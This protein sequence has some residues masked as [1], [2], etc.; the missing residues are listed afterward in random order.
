[1]RLHEFPD[2]FKELITIVAKSKSLP[3]SA[4]ERDYYIVRLLHNLATSEYADKCVFKGGTSLSKCYPGSIERFSEDIDLTYLGGPGM[5]DK[6]YSKNIKRI[7]AVMTVG[8]DTEKID[9]ERNDRN[10]SMLVWFG[11]RTNKVKLEIGS[12]VR[13][14]PYAPRT[15]RFYIHEF[16]ESIEAYED[17]EKFGLEPVTV[18]VLSIEK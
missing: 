3:E 18:N 12:T 2:E 7:E 1:M 15:M 14:D 4:V 16:L 6:L 11:D 10:K 13:P 9:S 5:S 8:A 17:I